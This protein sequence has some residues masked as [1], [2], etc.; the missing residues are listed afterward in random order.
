MKLSRYFVKISRYYVNVLRFNVIFSRYFAKPPRHNVIASP[1]FFT[2]WQ[3][4]AS[5]RLSRRT[6]WKDECFPARNAVRTYWQNKVRNLNY[7]IHQTSVLI[8][9]GFLLLLL[10]LFWNWHSLCWCFHI[11]WKLEKRKKTIKTRQTILAHTEMAWIMALDTISETLF[12][13]TK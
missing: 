2:G 7:V 5:V 6:S 13:Q 12:M 10:L 1:V 9:C 8:L 4:C 3:Q 11:H